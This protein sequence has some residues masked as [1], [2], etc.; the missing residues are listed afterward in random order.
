MSSMTCPRERTR[1]LR[2]AAEFLQE[3]HVRQEQMPIDLWRRLEDILEHFPTVDEVRNFAE[4]GRKMSF[5]VWCRP[6][7]EDP[8][9]EAWS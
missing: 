1:A 2:M 6:E 4:N 3:C 8:D 9:D 7:I 5:G